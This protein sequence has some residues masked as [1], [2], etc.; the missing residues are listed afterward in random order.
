MTHPRQS[1]CTPSAGT[2]AR[3]CPEG[4]LPLRRRRHLCRYRGRSEGTPRGG[5]THRSRSRPARRRRPPRPCGRH[6]AG[7]ERGRR[8][9]RLCSR[10]PPASPRQAP[11][12]RPRPRG[13]APGRAAAAPPGLGGPSSATGVS[14]GVL[15][16]D[17][18]EGRAPAAVLQV[19][20]ADGAVLVEHVL[21]VL[22]ADVGGQVPHVDAAV[23][24]A[25]RAADD[26]AAGHGE[27]GNVCGGAGRCGAAVAGPG[28]ALGALVTSP[29][30]RFKMAPAAPLALPL[31]APISPRDAAPAAA[32][33]ELTADQQCPR[34]PP[35]PHSSAPR[36]RG[37]TAK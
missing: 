34:L 12:A 5:D 8:T 7:G 35:R 21:D 25:G 30:R 10:S 23:V 2:G 28:R 22:G 11:L 4:L 29:D 14:P 31:R 20:V 17:E 13:H 37:S 24:V 16:L 1:L 27:V 33:P 6:R 3:T 15:E 32:P 18:G 26:A 9:P 19:D 36:M